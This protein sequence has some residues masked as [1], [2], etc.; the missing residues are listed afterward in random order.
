MHPQIRQNEPGSCP[1]CG[2]DLIPLDD[3][4]GDVLD[5]DQL[6]MTMGAAR[7]ADIQTTTVTRSLA[8]KTLSLSGQIV[9]D[10]TRISRL[11]ARFP[12][13]IEQLFVNYT[14]QYVRRGEKL[15]TVYSPELISAQKELFEA[16]K[17]RENSPSLYQAARSKLRL[18]DLTDEQIASIEES[19]EPRL[20][21]DIL[22]PLSGTV[23]HREVATGEYLSAGKALFEITDLSRLWVMFDA[24]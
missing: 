15:A 3:A 8:E 6:Q 24:Y 14:G 7:L 10:E 2:M 4:G 19:G 17:L 23:T 16:L 1:I 12:G 22:S 13:R 21:F 18:W 20:Y 11:T 9:P 5:V